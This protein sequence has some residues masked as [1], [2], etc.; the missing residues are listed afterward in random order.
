VD[1]EFDSDKAASN[2]RKHGVSFEYCLR[3]FGDSRHVRFDSSRAEDGEKRLK[4]VGSIDGL[5]FTVVFTMR[6]GTIRM[7]SARRS[8]RKEEKAYGNRPL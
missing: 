1:V 6:G 2:E 3:A 8:N 5:L 4:L 7:I